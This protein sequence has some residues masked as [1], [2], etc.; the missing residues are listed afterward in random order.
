ML[1]LK[2]KN[3]QIKK[4]LQTSFNESNSDVKIISFRDYTD[5]DINLGFSVGLNYKDTIVATIYLHSDQSEFS[6]SEESRSEYHL[7]CIKNI[8]DEKNLD[9]KRINPDHLM[10]DDHTISTYTPKFKYSQLV[11]QSIEPE[12]AVAILLTST[13]LD[14]H[15]KIRITINKAEEVKAINEAVSYICNKLTSNIIRM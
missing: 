7:S 15:F 5:H 6:H 12:A 13:F 2:E 9:I 10:R 11:H 3:L 1:T 8:I 4:I 14:F